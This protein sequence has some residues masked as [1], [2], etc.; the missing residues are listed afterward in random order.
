MI[1]NSV[2]QTARLTI[3]PFEIEDAPI[4]VAIFA[5]SLVSQFVGDGQALSSENADLWVANSRANLERYGYGTGAVIARANGQL[6][7]WAGFARP[8]DGPEQLIYGLSAAQWRQGFGGEILQVLVDFADRRGIDP[9]FATVD[10][11]NSVSIYLLT[12]H[13]FQLTEQAY[14]GGADTD[15]YQRKRQ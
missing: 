5:D 6:I 7:G 14:G 2:I 12:Q 15:L 3:R 10:P 13:D 4:L 11:L 9:L 8:Q 1:L